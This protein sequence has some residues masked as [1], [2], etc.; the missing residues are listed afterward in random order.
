MHCDI[1][2]DLVSKQQCSLQTMKLFMTTDKHITFSQLYI[3]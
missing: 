1:T 2:M 3:T